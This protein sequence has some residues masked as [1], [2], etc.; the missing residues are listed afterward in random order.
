M[1]RF[2]VGI[3]VLSALN[4]AGC[5]RAMTVNK[6]TAL[7]STG[8]L[9]SAVATSNSDQANQSS[10]SLVSAPPSNQGATTA[11]GSP[12]AFVV[13][14]PLPQTPVREM[15]AGQKARAGRA[16]GANWQSAWR[17]TL[18]PHSKAFDDFTDG[19]NL[20]FSRGATIWGVMA[21]V[22]EPITMLS[23]HHGDAP[24]EVTRVS[25]CIRPR[26]VEYGFH[27]HLGYVML[28]Q[29][30][31]G[32][33][34]ATACERFEHIQVYSPPSCPRRAFTFECVGERPISV[35]GGALK[36]PAAGFSPGVPYGLVCGAVRLKSVCIL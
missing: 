8:D 12:G 31:H 16:L 24:E 11:S 26:F 18:L 27:A 29:G 4:L 21:K 13:P 23:T 7:A 17:N 36:A 25:V 32:D 34:L 10:Q 5:G 35:E 19:G 15:L 14:L 28:P 33:P 1:N 22:E 9:T 6:K 2:L 3:V 20:E 30:S